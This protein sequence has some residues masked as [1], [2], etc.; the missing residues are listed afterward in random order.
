MPRPATLMTMPPM[1]ARVD[2]LAKDDGLPRSADELLGDGLRAARPSS[3]TAVVTSATT[4]PRSLLGDPA[5][6]F[7]DA[8]KQVEVAAAR[9]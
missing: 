7:G 4:T 8:R 3:A 5:V 1:M 6:R 9:P 2:L